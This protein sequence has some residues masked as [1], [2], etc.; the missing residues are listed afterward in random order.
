MT[1]RGMKDLRNKI[2]DPEEV[3]TRKEVAVEI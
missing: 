3:K 2:T 1:R